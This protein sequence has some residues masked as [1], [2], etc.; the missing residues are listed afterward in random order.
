MVEGSLLDMCSLGMQSLPGTVDISLLAQYSF[1]G[2]LGYLWPACP[3]LEAGG[4]R[5][6]FPRKSAINSKFL[7]AE[8]FG[9]SAGRSES[10]SKVLALSFRGACGMG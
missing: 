9:R 10:S 1:L 7:T 5:C 2:G 4:E 3:G 8:F 6:H